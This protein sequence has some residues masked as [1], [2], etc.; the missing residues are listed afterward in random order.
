MKRITI[1]LSLGLGV[2]FFA[3][4]NDIKRKAVEV[5]RGAV[6][7]ALSKTASTA[8]DKADESINKASDTA[9][10]NDKQSKDRN[11]LKGNDD[12]SDKDK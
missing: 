12:D 9:T 7:H 6:E 2:L 11:A 3:G 1:L 4:C 5:E 8:S 10:G